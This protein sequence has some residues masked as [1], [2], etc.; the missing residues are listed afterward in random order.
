MGDH[1]INDIKGALDAGMKA[2]RMNYG[3]FK[4]KDLRPDVPVIDKIIDVLKY[5]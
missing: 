2:I 4:D 3:W 5:V 1:P